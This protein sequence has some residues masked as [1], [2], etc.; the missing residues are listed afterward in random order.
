MKAEDDLSWLG[1][2][3]DT[4][5]L[6][7]DFSPELS[8]THQRSQSL[9]VGLHTQAQVEAPA[10]KDIL[11]SPSLYDL[12]HQTSLALRK[13]VAL[14]RSLLSL[15]K[16]RSSSIASSISASTSSTSITSAEDQAILGKPQA[17]EPLQDGNKP[18]AFWTNRPNTQR[19]TSAQYRHQILHEAI[20][21]SFSASETNIPALYNPQEMRKEETS[22][23][24]RIHSHGS[25][26][27]SKIVPR[28]L[29][30]LLERATNGFER[31]GEVT[32]EMPEDFDIRST[33]R[34]SLSRPLLSEEMSLL[35]IQSHSHADDGT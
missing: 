15:G 27:L 33:I 20:S 12:R 19:N 31:D 26:V 30:L 24:P 13:T 2:L 35:S 18:D 7:M 17:Y 5:N 10:K 6:P 23:E 25:T 16:S 11:T 28:R 14:R 21:T 4:P 34:K 1:S 29:S 32:E 3:N 8:C 9:P 22:Y